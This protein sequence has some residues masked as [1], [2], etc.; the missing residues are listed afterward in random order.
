MKFAVKVE[1]KG[2][3]QWG[4]ACV[5]RVFALLYGRSGGGPD[6]VPPTMTE[7]LA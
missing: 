5:A 1:L 2:R 4:I 3:K 6:V 7:R